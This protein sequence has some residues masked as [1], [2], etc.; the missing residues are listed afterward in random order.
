MS[1]FTDS[2]QKSEAGHTSRSG[3][4][5]YP[6]G[7]EIVPDVLVTAAGCK[8]PNNLAEI[9]LPVSSIRLS[10]QANS[11]VG[12]PASTT[13]NN[14][15]PKNTRSQTKEPALSALERRQE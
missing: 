8:I 1:R 11:K 10:E 13:R 14:F 4:I 5:G 9:N 15:E 3:T 7:C 2:S 12:S 6:G